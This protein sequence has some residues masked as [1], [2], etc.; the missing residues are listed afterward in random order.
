MQT[1]FFVDSAPSRDFARVS[2]TLNPFIPS[3]P[4]TCTHNIHTSFCDL[5]IGK[6]SEFRANQFKSRNLI[7]QCADY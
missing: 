7:G 1:I 3:K 6:A 2:T 4:Y 5:I